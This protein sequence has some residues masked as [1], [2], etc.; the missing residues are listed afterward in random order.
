MRPPFMV[1]S[2]AMQC[3]VE[4][5]GKTAEATLVPQFPAYYS[6]YYTLIIYVHQCNLWKLK[7]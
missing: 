5:S 7:K 2:H 3:V 4:A 1:F 6:Y